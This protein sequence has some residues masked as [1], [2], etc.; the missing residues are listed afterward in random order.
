MAEDKIRFTPDEVAGSAYR[1]CTRCLGFEPGQFPEYDSLA[2]DE[3]KPWRMLARAAD[4]LLE[5]HNGRPWPEAAEALWN[6]IREYGIQG[7]LVGER[8]RLAWEATTRHLASLIQTDDD[9]FD[10][11][12]AEE[13]WPAWVD[14]KVAAS[15]AK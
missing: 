9:N 5:E 15:A 13:R 10:L 1:V 3:Q 2:H 4:V 14:R 7:E 6:R 11:G 8:E 12:A